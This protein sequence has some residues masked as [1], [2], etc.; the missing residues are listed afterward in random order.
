MQTFPM[1]SRRNVITLLLTLWQ[2]ASTAVQTFV[3]GS[4]REGAINVRPLSRTLRVVVIVGLTIIGIFLLGI[5]FS[6]VLRVSGPLEFLANESSATRALHA[7][8]A[9]FPITL[10]ALSLGWGYMLAGALHARRLIRWFIFIIFM[11]YML[12]ANIVPLTQPY[13]N[14]FI[15]FVFL[16]FF[17]LAFI[18]LPRVHLPLPLEWSFILLLCGSM[19]AMGLYGNLML[20]RISGENWTSTTLTGLILNQLIITTPFLLLS[21]LGW[22]DFA[23]EASGWTASAVRRHASN[24]L[25]IAIL[26][27]ILLFRSYEHLSGLFLAPLSE[28]AAK[29]GGAS[30]FILGLIMIFLWRMHQPGQGNV[31]RRLIVGLLLVNIFIQVILLFSQAL[32]TIPAIIMVT[33]ESERSVD[34][35][36]AA[37]LAVSNLEP[38]LRPWIFALIGLGLSVFAKRRNNP[39]LV[40]FGFILIW[41]NVLRALTMAD[42][43]LESLRYEYEHVDMVGTVLLTGL[44]LFWLIKRK[45]N[46]ERAIRLLVIAL[47]MALLN[48]T[49]FLDNPFSP[50]FSFAGVAF[51]VFGIIWNIL[52]A[53]SFANLSTPGLPRESRLLLYIGYVLIS[54]AITHWYLV[55]HNIGRQ[56]FTTTINE[57]GFLSLGLPIAY[58]AIAEGGQRLLHEDL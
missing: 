56:L 47:L 8:S 17:L 48:Q 44:A 39:S 12:F 27:G 25:I 42:R 50:L 3:L 40:A 23:L 45:L 28:Q 54:V 18:I 4:V 41:F 36:S 19:M 22:A 49:S 29:L 16:I 9:A 5:L 11:V 10:V 2:I 43:P 6:D 58:L 13:D 30:L 35:I 33:P 21:G 31:Q 32:F 57:L 7:P 20:E 53:G 52:M 37:V 26:L 24:S 51:L 55:S 38:K 15:P 1:P 14:I 46:A 34:R